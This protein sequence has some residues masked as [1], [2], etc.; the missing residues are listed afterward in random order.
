MRKSG[1]VETVM[2]VLV[3]DSIGALART[4]AFEAVLPVIPI[5]CALVCWAQQFWSTQA[6]FPPDDTKPGAH[7][8][9]SSLLWAFR[10]WDQS[11]T[12]SVGQP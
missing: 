4:G 9:H 3:S 2:G 6:G 11:V 8:V 5:C 10:P 12:S 7:P 1:V